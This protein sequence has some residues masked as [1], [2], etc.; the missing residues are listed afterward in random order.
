MLEDDEAPLASYEW[1]KTVKQ[2]WDTVQEDDEGNLVSARL[3]SDRDRS[4]RAKQNRVTQS[5]RRGLIRYLCVAMDT[6]AAAAESNDYRPNRLLVMRESVKRF[7]TDYFEENP[8]SQLSLM[9]MHS[10]IAEKIT[11]LSANPRVHID[12][13]QHLWQTQGKVSLGNAIEVAITS[14]QNVPEYGHRELLIIFCSLNTTDPDPIE[15]SIEKAKAQRI[16]ISIICLA[17]EI[18]VCKMICERTGGQCRVALDGMHLNELMRSHTAPH[19]ELR[20]T[21]HSK[22]EYIYM[23]FP[24]KVQDPTPVFCFEGKK[25]A[26]QAASFVCPRC[27]TRAT[28]IPTQC[29]TCGLQLNSSTHIARSHHHLFPVP[30]FDELHVSGGP[31]NTGAGV[32]AVG[33]SSSSSSSSSKRQRE[34]L[35]PTHCKGCLTMLPA[36]AL[37]ARCPNCF[38]VFCVECDL[39]IHDQLHTCPGCG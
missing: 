12:R 34:H 18:H 36:G 16:R 9:V 21:V 2:T 15:K 14:L 35:D 17:A 6:S 33:D 30:N 28:E 20:N 11:E 25:T 24:K 3:Q 8:I 31:G 10:R 5:V 39:F 32:E 1:E 23:G 27:Q 13:L 37:V 26:F 22:A 29:C 19:P 4:H 38:F 7:I